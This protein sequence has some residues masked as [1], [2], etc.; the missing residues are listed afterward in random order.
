MEM[1]LY[2]E[3]FGT[4]LG[5]A[6]YNNIQIDLPIAPVIYK[7]LL[8]GKPNLTDLKNWQPEV[9]NS[10]LYILDYDKPEPMKDILGTTFSLDYQEYGATHTV[11]LIPNGREIYVTKDN[12][13]DYV[14]LYIEYEFEKQCE[15]PLASFKK[16]FERLCDIRLIRELLDKDELE[17]TIC[18]ERVLDFTELRECA[19]YCNGFTRDC[20]EMK[21]FW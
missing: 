15:V 21:W 1:P 12:R 8:N 18:G 3:L 14:R 4:L 10:M 19:R 17:Q 7:L 6:L 9:A 13:E 2:F 16:G 5:I 20:K 11:D